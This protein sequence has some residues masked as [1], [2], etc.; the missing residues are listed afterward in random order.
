MT[1]LTAFRLGTDGMEIPNEL[2]SEWDFFLK[3]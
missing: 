2:L 3:C 1:F